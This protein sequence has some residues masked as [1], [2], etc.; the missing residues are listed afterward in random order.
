MKPDLAERIRSWLG[1]KECE[2]FFAAIRAP[3]PGSVRIN[4]CRPPPADLPLGEPVPWYGSGYRWAGSEPPSRHP[5]YLGGSYYIQEAGAMLVISALGASCDLDKARVLDLAAAPGGKSTQAAELTPNGLLVANEIDPRRRQALIWN[6]VRHRCDN[7]LVTGRSPEDLAASLPGYF[8]VVILDAPCSGEGLLAKGKLSL[9]EWGIGRIRR[10][11]ALQRQLL[12]CA[13]T[14]LRP[15]GVLAYS[16]CT[17]APEENEDQIRLLMEDGMIPL[18]FPAQLPAS[19]ALSDMPE[20]ASC[21][22]RLWPHRDR[23]AGA[24]AALLQKPAGPLP[25]DPGALVFPRL[26]SLPFP[27]TLEQTPLYQKN[28]ILSRLSYSPLP[29][30]LHQAAVQIGTPICDE[31]RGR[32]PLFGCHRFI[33]EEMTL[34]LSEEEARCFHRGETAVQLPREGLWTVA[35]SGLKLGLMEREKG[36]SLNLLPLPLRTPSNQGETRSS[37]R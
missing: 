35:W 36:R 24:F 1:R 25:T 2:E 21:S 13:R 8:D 27:S 22:R 14:L 18:P 23:S 34:N 20:V 30:S 17:F 7:T 6:L 29:A 16:T 32:R 26:S 12:R 28:G 3:I 11:A 19:P 37:R 33:P 31:P 10:M 15:G 4:T 9:S 5:A